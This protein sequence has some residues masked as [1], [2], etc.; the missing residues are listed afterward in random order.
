LI[1]RENAIW[2]KPVF[3]FSPATFKSEQRWIQM[4]DYHRRPALTLIELLVAIAI[5]AVLL[6]ILLPAIQKAREAAYRTRCSNNL[7]QLGVAYFNY[8][9]VNGA[10]PPSGLVDA[11]HATSHTSLHNELIFHGWA[12]FLLPYIE[13]G[14]LAAQYDMSQSFTSP[15][16][17]SVIQ[18]PL[19]LMLCPSAIHGSLTYSDTILGV[20]YTA[21]V[22]DYAPIFGIESDAVNVLNNPPYSVNPPYVTNDMLGNAPNNTLGA[23]FQTWQGPAEN[24]AIV[25]EMPVSG[26][27]RITDISDGASNT[28]LLVED[29]GRPEVYHTGPKDTFTRNVNAQ[30]S[31]ISSDSS[32]AGWGDF[33]ANIEEKFSTPDGTGRNGACAIN[34]NNDGE[35]FS[36]HTGGANTLFC[37]GSVRFVASNVNIVVWA[38]LIT[39][40]GGEVIAAG[41]Y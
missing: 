16:N 14:A 18:S 5:V 39:A 20:P 40:Q 4:T 24:L 1:L 2:A 3:L 31:L 12:V 37:D 11:S 6:G 27:R 19:S 17:Q 30:P 34:C 13:Q 23:T 15:G 28:L 21:A 26:S 9:S 25:G 41:S 38:A 10:L 35:T 32:G 29:A 33:N 8:E 22:G 36:F 7:K